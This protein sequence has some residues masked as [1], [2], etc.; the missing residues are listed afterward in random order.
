MYPSN[1]LNQNDLFIY[2]FTGGAR[3][4]MQKVTSEGRT[5]YFKSYSQKYRRLKPILELLEPEYVRGLGGETLRRY[6]LTVDEYNSIT[7]TKG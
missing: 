2:W 1:M 6:R 7:E 3:D 4:H 5:H